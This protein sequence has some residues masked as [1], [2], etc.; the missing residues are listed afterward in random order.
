MKQIL[1]NLN[2]GTTKANEVPCPQASSG[3]LLIRTTRS[4]IS[5]GTERMMVDFGKANPIDKARQQPDKVRMVL[6]KIKTDGLM[7]TLD[8]VRNKL[9]QP[10]PLG[11]CNVG[12]VV[13]TGK[14]VAGFEVG[15]RIASNGKHAEVVSVPV[16]LCAR[17]PDMV[18]DDEAAF[19]VLGAIALQG[20]R[21]VQP[22]LGEA[23]VVTGLG[24]IGQLTVQ[25]LRAHGCRVLGIDLDATRLTLAKS[26]GAEV[27]NL[28]VG[29]DPVGAA[30][31]FSRGRG[32]DA[33]IVTAATKSSEPIHQAALMCRKRGRIV[34]VGVTG[35]VLSRDDFFKKEL[36]FQVSA[37]YGPGR[38]DPN[39]EEKGQDYPVGFVRWTEQRNLEA[40][41]DMMASGRLDVKPLISHRFSLE[42]TET[43]YAVVGGSEPSMGILL[44]YPTV[45]DKPDALVRGANVRLGGEGVKRVKKTPS[46]AF[47]GSGNYATGVL[48]PAFKEAGAHL[49]TVASSAGVSGVHAGKK[50]GFDE[51]TTD[52]A[53][54][55]SDPKVDA[56]VVTTRHNSHAQF[57]LQA[58]AA[59]KHVFVEKPLCLTLGELAEI[60]GAMDCG[61]E[62]AMTVPP[63]VMVGF[64]RRFAAQV[65]KVKALLAGVTGPKAFVMTVNAGAIPADH[66]AQDAEVGGGRIIG[67]AC[68]FIDLLR[69]LSGARITSHHVT[70]MDTQTHDSVSISL[71]FEDGSIGTV[72]YLANGS[73]AFPKERLEVFA[74]G[75]VLQLDNFRK[76]RGFGWPGFSKMNL[77]RQDKGQKACAAEFIK[78]IAQGGPAPI[79][80][81][82]IVEVARVS[83]EVAGAV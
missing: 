65:Q 66:W 25:L 38:Y 3:Q 82:E 31:R 39:Y 80:F 35:L 6:E 74:A 24:L 83:I 9:D 12:V 32:V 37:S 47:V 4:L 7:P 67:E 62:S 59:G 8:A 53:S 77:W 33:V 79:P 1:Q 51:T 18:S 55:F 75:R 19:T 60:R 28:G 2:N 46:V 13:E 45:L 36:T 78:S 57:V 5:A 44:E 20:I 23:V 63:M 54:L 40:V 34:L 52:T 26:F 15:D 43:A 42:Q 29:E 56:L 17:I 69:F 58:L 76:L 73:K 30:E 70:K 11:Y 41:L 61:S 71:G 10:L 50:F 64:N 48:I 49:A 22:T 16:N 72:H 14:G 21:L 68:H 27:V 81:D